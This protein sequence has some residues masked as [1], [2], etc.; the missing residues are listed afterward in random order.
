MIVKEKISTKHSMN[1]IIFND[2]PDNP[3][4]LSSYRLL[5]SYYQDMD[6][7]FQEEN[8]WR[9]Y[10]I[11]RRHFLRKRRKE[12]GGFWVCHYCG[13]KITKMQKR[14]AKW[15]Q[16]NCITVDHVVPASDPE[17]DKL[18]TSNMVESCNKCNNDKGTQPYGEFCRKTRSI[19]MH[20]G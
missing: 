2:K 7:S 14:N 18:D 3:K 13:K 1:H 8:D 5:V 6:V 16:P 19:R 20:Q 10:F 15:Q 4:T 9:Y 17:C 11:V 12:N